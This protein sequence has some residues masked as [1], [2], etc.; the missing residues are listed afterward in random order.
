MR[1]AAVLLV[2]AVLAT[3]CAAGGAP[4]QRGSV[5]ACT[6]AAVQAI[7]HHVTPATLPA[8]CRGLHRAQLN[9]A[10]GRAVFDVAGAGRHKAAWRRGAAI[11]GA[12]LARLIESLPRPAA[13]ARPGRGRPAPSRA[14]PA[15]G[16]ADGLVTLAAWLLTVGSGAFMLVRWIRHGGLRP[17]AGRG[18]LAPAVTLGHAGA[19]STGLLVW[20]GYLATGWTGLAWLAVGVLLAV[21]GLG[22]ATL[23]VWTAQASRSRPGP[24][25]PE[26]GPPRRTW[27]GLRIIVPI[28]HGLTAS[29]TILLA[30]LT[31]LSA[32]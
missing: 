30:L 31:V 32:R 5:P 26:P 29:A 7:A 3:A 10:L 14:A 20:I 23:T 18:R 4:A 15:G 12:R 11:A 27:G 8:G 6:A 22:M 24:P 9:L 13:P 28:G 16:G 17:R 2:I 25:A 21:I 19:A 1:R